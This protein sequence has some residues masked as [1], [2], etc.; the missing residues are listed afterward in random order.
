MKLISATVL[1]LLASSAQAVLLFDI[2]GPGPLYEPRELKAWDWAVDN[3][4]S[5]DSVG[6]PV[7]TPFTVYAQFELSDV[8]FTDG[9]EALPIGPDGPFEITTL[10]RIE[11]E[12]A[13]RIGTFVA[14]NIVGGEI[15]VY[16]DTLAGPV[17][18]NA[19]AL[20]NNVGN[21]FNAYENGLLIL[22]ADLRVTDLAS[23]FTQTDPGPVPLDQFGADEAGVQTVL[24]F[25]AV[26]FVSDVTFSNPAWFTDM[27]ADFVT[28]IGTFEIP[29]GSSNPV[30]NGGTVGPRVPDY[31]GGVNG[32]LL[33]SDLHTE[34][35]ANTDFE[36]E[37]QV[38]PEPTTLGLLGLGLLGWGWL[39]RHRLTPPLTRLRT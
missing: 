3:T 26:N 16:Y 15:N 9:S 12:I 29:F 34:A 25:G 21:L 19:N 18:D 39:A 32:A 10:I 23:N 31:D 1:L 30:A 28:T 37:P 4:I 2:D 36:D 27:V 8:L 14:S 38:I 17:S 33:G 24:G 13:S 11:A 5:I 20:T 22:A 35:D 7:G 6:T